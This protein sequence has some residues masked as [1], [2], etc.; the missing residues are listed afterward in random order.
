G[1]G[2]VVEPRQ[3]DSRDAQGHQVDGRTADY[4]VGAVPDRHDSV[5]PANEPAHQHASQYADPGSVRHHGSRV[6]GEVRGLHQLRRYGS[7]H[8]SEEDDALE[9]DVDDAGALTEQTT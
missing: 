8:G 4:L 3:D 5:D 9:R 1:S 2:V 7:S 6:V